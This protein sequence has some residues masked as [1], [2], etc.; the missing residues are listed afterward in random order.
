M[1]DSVRA[2]LRRVFS[3]PRNVLLAVTMGALTLV[4]AGTGLAASGAISTAEPR[5]M[6]A[7]RVGDATPAPRAGAI[8]HK[9]TTSRDAWQ[10][11]ASEITPTNTPTQTPT[12]TPV[13]PTATA[14]P[15][16]PRPAAPRAPQQPAAPSRPAPP[17]PTATPRP[18]PQVAGLNTA[19][20]GAFE[21]ALFDA[22]NARRV[23]NGLPQLRPNL[24]LVGVA[25]I[26]SQEMARYGYF[27]HDSPISGPNAAFTLMD[28]YGIPYAW[29]GENLAM[30]NYPDAETVAVA[31]EALWN[32]PPHRSNIM[33]AH[34]TDMGIGFAVGADGIKY[35]TIIFTG[36]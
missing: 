36:P 15:A 32:S 25:R 10:Y 4:A 20:M 34:Y 35:F 28:S 23:A 31:D 17:P 2:V 6:G 24:N 33:G 22:T 30:N 5:T 8:R 16:P 9:D 27:S 18:A 3:S 12:W 7:Q 29:A 11:A 21:Q 1:P 26:R 14:T 19:P 13:P